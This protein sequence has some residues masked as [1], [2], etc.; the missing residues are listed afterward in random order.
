M[1]QQLH[2]VEKGAVGEKVLECEVFVQSGSV[3]A[4]LER[5]VAA[6]RF[7]L[8]SKQKAVAHLRIVH[9]LNAKPVA[10]EQKALTIIVP[11]GEGEHSVESV[12]AC[13]A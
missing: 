10:G 7:H 6:K 3:E 13:A 9:R 1:R 5:W 12:D 8:R 11:D 4:R 2:A